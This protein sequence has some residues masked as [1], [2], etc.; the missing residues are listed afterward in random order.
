MTS[1]PSIQTAL[2]CGGEFLVLRIVIV[3][4]HYFLLVSS[5]VL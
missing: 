3:S 2:N 1:R 4:S 5:Q